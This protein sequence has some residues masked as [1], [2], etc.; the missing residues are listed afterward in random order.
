MSDVCGYSYVL[1]LKAYYYNGTIR[2]MGIKINIFSP[3][4]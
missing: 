3:R 4:S 1:V 2:A